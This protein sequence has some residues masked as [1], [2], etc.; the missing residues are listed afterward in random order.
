MPSA[1]RHFLKV[2]IHKMSLQARAQVATAEY[3]RLQT[4]LQN[5]VE[6]RQRLDAQLSENEMVK[7]VSTRWSPR[8]MTQ[9]Y[10]TRTSGIRSINIQQHC[11]QTGWTSLGATRSSGCEEQC[12]YATGLHSG[13]NVH[14][15]FSCKLAQPSNPYARCYR[16]RLEGQLKEIGAKSE[17]KK[18]EVCSDTPAWRI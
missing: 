18:N 8:S 1:P 4:D 9:S 3:Q 11:I 14:S 17:K 15:N 6:A 2:N 12:R 16:K 7:K 13:R 5:A 10:D